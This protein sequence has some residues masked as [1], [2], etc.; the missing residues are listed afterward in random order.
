MEVELNLEK[1][2][3]DQWGSFSW[4]R[5]MAASGLHTR[6]HTYMYMYTSMFMRSSRP[7]IL[8]PY[9]PLM[10]PILVS[11]PLFRSDRGGRGRYNLATGE[12]FIQT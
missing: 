3:S 6:K 8:W 4:P 10:K 12:V 7:E 2:E 1:E 5:V 9:V 11:K